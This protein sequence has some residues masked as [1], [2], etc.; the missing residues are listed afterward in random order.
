MNLNYKINKLISDNI[1]YTR[2]TEMAWRCWGQRN[3]G[4]T[5]FDFVEKREMNQ[6]IFKKKK[7]KG[8]KCEYHKNSW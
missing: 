5:P 7:T 1:K 8:A 4:I 6:R 3:V 2:N